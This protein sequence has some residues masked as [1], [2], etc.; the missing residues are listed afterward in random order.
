MRDVLGREQQQR[1]RVVRPTTSPS[2]LSD[3]GVPS[4]VRVVHTLQEYKDAVVVDRDGL[5]LVGFFASDWC[6][7]CQAAVPHFYRLAR[8]HPD[9]TFVH[10]PVTSTNVNLHQ[11]LG[12]TSLPS[13]H[14]YHPTAGLVEDRLRL[15][16]RTIAT[17]VATI[18][19]SYQEGRCDLPTDGDERGTTTKRP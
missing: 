15:T 2:V 6:K 5:V 19:R 13:G 10:V 3:G 16:K 12:V 14:L 17:D 7:A 1:R 18:L 11:G 9:V 4:N 8:A